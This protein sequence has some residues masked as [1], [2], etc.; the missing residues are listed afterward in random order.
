[1]I[2][3]RSNKPLF[4][5]ID[6]PVYC[7]FFTLGLVGTV[8]GYGH[9]MVVRIVLINLEKS[10]EFQINSGIDDINCLFISGT[11]LYIVYDPVNMLSQG[12]S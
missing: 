1:M 6:A 10:L 11:L 8:E 3:Q 12:N 5:V 4:I 7:C 9:Y 2:S